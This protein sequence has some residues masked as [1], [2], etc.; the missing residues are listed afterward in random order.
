MN[1][2]GYDVFVSYKRKTGEDFAQ[3]LNEGLEGEGFSVFLDVANIPQR[4][5][6]TTE[7]A[8]IRDG[9]ISQSRLFL[10]IITDGIESSSEVIREVKCAQKYNVDFAFLRHK[11]LKSEITLNLGD[12][13]LD[14]SKLNQVEFDTKEDLLR[15]VLRIL[16][17]QPNITTLQ[18]APIPPSSIPEKV[19]IVEK[20]NLR[21]F[22]TEEIIGQ[23]EDFQVDLLRGNWFLKKS[24][25]DKAIDLYERALIA[26]PDCIECLDN[27][28]VALD[29]LGKREGAIDSL[30]RAIAIKPVAF[31]LGLKATIL[32]SQGRF[33][34]AITVYDKAIEMQPLAF[35]Y[36]NKA[37][38]LS[39]LER[40]IEA[41]ASY[42]KAIEIDSG[43]SDPWHG[44][45]LALFQLG[46]FTDAIE[47]CDRAISIDPSSASLK[48]KGFL[49]L[50]LNLF[51]EAKLLY[52]Q[53]LKS[54][55][56][57]S[58]TLIGHSVTLSSR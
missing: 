5:K 12:R 42:D 51:N 46:K 10:L 54:E 49:L 43:D 30:D 24:N 52:E 45:A 36:H 41:I 17:E 48:L 4:Y 55:P 35:A 21:A 6:G 40:Y 50:N 33:E 31:S 26:K 16:R 28:A 56:D 14:L 3:H 38:Y 9:A 57:S 39:K 22:S 37:H 18:K 8:Q 53:V 19:N 29:S 25:Y 32:G 2:S 1:S 15:K 58:I 34:E 20:Y 13:A 27:K 44:K 47:C 11:G 7:W 23:L